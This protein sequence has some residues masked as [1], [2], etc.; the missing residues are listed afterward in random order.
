M[1]PP[2]GGAGD[3]TSAV[4]TI[5]QAARAGDGNRIRAAMDGQ[6]DPLVRKIGLWAM[7]DAAP[8]YLTWAEADQARRDLKDWPRPSRREIAAEKLLDRSSMSPSA[9]IA[10]FDK[11][12]PLTP[13]GAMALAD[14]LR[15]DGQPEPATTIIRHAWRTMAFDQATQQTML[16]RFHDVLKQ[17]DIEAREDFLLYGAQ[18]PAAADLL[19]QLTPDQ[20][21][22]A[23][24]RMA[25][26]ANDPNAP[27]TLAALPAADQT[28][29][30]VVYERL[31]PLVDRGEIGA[32]LALV[33]YLPDALPNQAAA[34]R[35]WQKGAMFK[36]VFRAGD[37]EGAYAIASHSGLVGGPEAAD[38]RVARASQR[39]D[40]QEHRRGPDDHEDVGH[41]VE[42]ADRQERADPVRVRADPR[43]QVAGPLAAEELER[44]AVE[45]PVRL[46]S[47]SR[48]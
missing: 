42:H 36:T 33:G 15:A 6:P 14:S 41:E 46:H 47:A 8:D 23:K 44:E 1:A 34:E 16:Y 24:V 35:L 4:S 28:S 2:F 40:G 43:H 48:R 11:G 37:Y 18:G 21:A 12:D 10:W 20:Q 29:P 9:I 17:P 3:Q 38:A 19:P 22:V 32:S 31:L 39:V 27:A 7:A 13:Q 30:G 26:R 25:L 45:V 5:L